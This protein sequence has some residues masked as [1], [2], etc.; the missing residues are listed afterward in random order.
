[1]PKRLFLILGEANARKSSL[2]RCLTGIGRSGKWSVCSAS[3]NELPVYVQMTSLQEEQNT[4]SK[5]YTAN[6][7]MEI[8]DDRAPEIDTILLPLRITG[9][10]IYFN[11]FEHEGFTIE[12]V[13]I[14]QRKHENYQALETTLCRRYDCLRIENSNTQPS[15]FT[16]SKIRPFFGWT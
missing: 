13:V 10:E 11:D 7:F 14:L 4:E 9:H 6:E 1:M 8:L 16:A 3:G 2:I 15:S 12:K 5:S